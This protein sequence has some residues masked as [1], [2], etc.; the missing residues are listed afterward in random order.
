VAIGLYTVVYIRFSGLT[1]DVKIV[2]PKNKKP[3]KN[4][5]L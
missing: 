1:I 3:I 2:D 5:I 4:A